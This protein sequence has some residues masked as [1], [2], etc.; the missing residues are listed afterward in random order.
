MELVVPPVV[1]NMFGMDPYAVPAAVA[2][3]QLAFSLLTTDM[4][5]CVVVL[6]SVPLG[7]PPEIEGGGGAA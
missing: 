6:E 2:Y 1:A 7:C 3:L 5:A 4:V